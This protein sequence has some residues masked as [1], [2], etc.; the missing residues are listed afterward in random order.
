MMTSSLYS[1]SSSGLISPEVFLYAN[2]SARSAS[3][4]GAFTLAS[5]LAVFELTSETANC[6]ACAVSIA[7]YYFCFNSTLLLVKLRSWNDTELSSVLTVRTYVQL[8][9]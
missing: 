8:H 1:S 2:S 9:G 4:W 7:I 6:Y 3:S 5:S